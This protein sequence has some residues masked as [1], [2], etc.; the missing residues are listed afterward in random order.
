MIDSTSSAVGRSITFTATATGGSTPLQYKWLVNDGS[1][2]WTTLASWSTLN[3]FVWTPSAAN[4]NY[5]VS[6]WARSNGNTRDEPEAST[7]MSY[8]ITAASPTPQPAPPATVTSVSLSTDKPAPQPVGTTIRA[9]ATVIG[10]SSPYSF[11]WFV[12]DGS[13]EVAMTGWVSSNTYDWTPTQADANYR[14]VVWV[15]SSGNNTDQ[16]EQKATLQ[17]RIRK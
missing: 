2:T 16:A 8:P 15:R 6:V 12:N 7:S 11:K 3:T 10:G 9:T 17:Y 5:S 1:Q 4:A 13:R 14:I